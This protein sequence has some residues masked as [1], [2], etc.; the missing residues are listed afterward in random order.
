MDE[1]HRLTE[2]LIHRWQPESVLVYGSFADGTEDALSDFDALVI[3]R[4]PAPPRDQ[5]PLMGR[6]QD[7]WFLRPET[8]DVIEPVDWPQLYH[9]IPL[10]DPEGMGERLIADVR[11]AVDAQPL[12]SPS[13]L[14]DELAW[15]D[16]MLARAASGSEEGRYRL[17]W[18]ITDSLEI[19]CGLA[20]RQS[21]GA[22]KSLALLRS[23]DPEGHDLYSR[24]LMNPATETA[25]AWVAHLRGMADRDAEAVPA[26]RSES[27]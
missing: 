14:T 11:E 15:M 26:Q 27:T 1:M 13:Q 19:W 5:R 10:W 8:V 12:P 2:A 22:K 4:E 25:A 7:V 20:R 24:A 21:F 16:R 17:L 18:L 3:T 23:A 6:R 9:A